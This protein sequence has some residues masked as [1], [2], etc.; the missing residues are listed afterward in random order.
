MM[1]LEK[2]SYSISGCPRT[3]NLS[4]SRLQEANFG[5]SGL[6]ER[7]PRTEAE[8]RVYVGFGVLVVLST[9]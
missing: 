6:L 1:V 5:R 8:P 9:L 7:R 2:R 3:D 4:I